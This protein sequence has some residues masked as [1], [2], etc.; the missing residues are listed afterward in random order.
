MS[1]NMIIDHDADVCARARARARV[2]VCVCVCV[3]R[4]FIFFDL[5]LFLFF[6]PFLVCVYLLMLSL[7]ILW[8]F[9]YFSSVNYSFHDV[10]A[11]MPRQLSSPDSFHDN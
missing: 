6:V 4:L 5:F 1:Q 9:R 8:V 2:C 11:F 10:T 7:W 3:L